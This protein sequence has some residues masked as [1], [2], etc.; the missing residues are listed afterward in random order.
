SQA[1]PARDVAGR[2]RRL[3]IGCWVSAALLEEDHPRLFQQTIVR[4]TKWEHLARGAP[5]PAEGS[6]ENEA[7]LRSVD[8][9]SRC[10]FQSIFVW[11]IGWEPGSNQHTCHK[12]KSNCGNRLR[13]REPW[14]LQIRRNSTFRAQ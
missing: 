9:P 1:P 13:P 4:N 10:R 2:R 6:S 14:T 8:L 7:G 12:L 3:S 11:R 5:P